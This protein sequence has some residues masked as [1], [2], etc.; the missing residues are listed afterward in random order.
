M[1]AID[2]LIGDGK[3]RFYTSP[4]WT[5]PDG[6]EVAHKELLIKQYLSDALGNPEIKSQL[7]DQ[8]SNSNPLDIF[9]SNG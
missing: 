3:I 9:I 5:N 4:N 8:L 1:S 7:F 6:A 2:D